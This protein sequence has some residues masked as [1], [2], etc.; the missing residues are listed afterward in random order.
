LAFRTDDLAVREGLL[1]TEVIVVGAWSAPIVR[2]TFE[3][4]GDHWCVRGPHWW[5]RCRFVAK[6][7]LATELVIALDQLGVTLGRPSLRDSKPTT[8]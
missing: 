1:T 5:S 3:R 4:H 7:T 8:F 6:P 2:S